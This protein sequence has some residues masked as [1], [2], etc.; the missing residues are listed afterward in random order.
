MNCSRSP[1]KLRQRIFG[2]IPRSSTTSR[3]LPGGEQTDSIV[4]GHW[5]SLVTPSTWRTVGRL[6]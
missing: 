5:I 4:D 6:T 3:S 1:Q 2:S